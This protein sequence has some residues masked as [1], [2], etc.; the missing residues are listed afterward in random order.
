MYPVD[1]IAGSIAMYC[2]YCNEDHNPAETFSDEHIIPEALGGSKSFA[3]RVCETINNT[4]GNE[5][6]KP[7]IS[8]FPV[9]ADRFF[10]NLPSHRGMPTVDFSGITVIDGKERHITSTVKDGKKVL[11]LTKAVTETTHESDRHLVTISADPQEARKILLGRLESA[12]KQGKAMTHQ[13]GTPVTPA[14]IDRYIAQ[15]SV[16]VNQPSILIKLQLNG[17]EAVRFFC[18]VA[19]AIGFKIA[20]ESFGRFAVA[21]KLRTV[22][23]SENVEDLPM[24]GAFWPFYKNPEAFN[25]FSVPDTHVLAVLPDEPHVLAISLFGGSYTALVPLHE[26]ESFEWPLKREGQV[27][28]ISLKDKSFKQWSYDDYLLARPWIPST[29]Q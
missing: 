25:F 8:M 12:I 29:P 28:Q 18:K 5:V 27:F 20:E 26:P 24:P 3:I 4:F 7:F 15:H 10:L 11:R 2:V 21:D 22:I 19:L 16:T 23:R 13:V 14:S 1:L 9:N 6:D 17:V